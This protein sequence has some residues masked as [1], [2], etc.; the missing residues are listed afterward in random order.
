MWRTPA[1][2]TDPVR[3]GA[4]EILAPSMADTGGVSGADMAPVAFRP[5]TG[6]LPVNSK[7]VARAAILS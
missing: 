3:Q 2:T 7:A 5:V 6:M 1:G 4:I